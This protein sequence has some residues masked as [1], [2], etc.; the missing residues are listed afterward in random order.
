MQA[1]WALIALALA[2]AVV[3]LPDEWIEAWYSTSLYPYGQAAITSLSNLVPI[4]LID[5]LLVV[6]AFGWLVALV[7]DGRRLAWR[8]TAWRALLRTATVASLLYLAFLAAWGLNYRRVPLEDRL[9]L[10]SRGVTPD[11]A[12]RLART[13]V[14]E[15]NRLYRPAN[16]RPGL[17]DGRIDATLPPALASVQRQLDA[18]RGIVPA[19]PKRS[20]LDAYFRAASVD[21][22]TDPWFL[23]TLTLSTLLPFERPMVIAHEWAHLAGFADEG[24]ANFVGW[25]A[26][27]R[28]DDAARYSAWLFLYAEAASALDDGQRRDVVARLADGPRADLRAINA[29]IAAH[30]NVVVSDVGWGLYDQYLKANGIERGRR[31]YTDVV[32]L[33]LGTSLGADA[34]A[35]VSTVSGNA[36]AP[37]VNA[38]TPPAG[39]SPAPLPAR[40]TP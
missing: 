12:E 24:E 23:E 40:Q 19:R 32:R 26:C 31:S 11:A 3:P 5:V 34:L 39:Q 1:R 28:A 6:V 13:A 22:M 37:D 7:G 2:A 18:P 20:L 9:Q 36:A 4:A 8:R 16:E 17:T 35:T 10:S 21:G 33:V 29:R 30:V 14:A 38:A 25:L 15:L 27:L